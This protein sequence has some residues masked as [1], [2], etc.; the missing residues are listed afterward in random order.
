LKIHQDAEVWL[1]RL[2]AGET[3]KIEV[4]EGK[5]AWVQVVEGKVEIGGERLGT[6]DAVGV[7]EMA[8]IRAATKTEM[9]GFVV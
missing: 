6:S 4:P 8:E 1:W 2:Q 7:G 5:G 9:M 3:A